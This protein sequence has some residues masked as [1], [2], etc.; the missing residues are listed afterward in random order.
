MDRT[1]IGLA[2]FDTYVDIDSVIGVPDAAAQAAGAGAGRTAPPSCGP[3]HGLLC[4]VGAAKQRVINAYQST[5][6]YTHCEVYFPKSVFTRAELARII[7]PPPHIMS[8]VHE[9]DMVVAFAAFSDVRPEDIARAKGIPFNRATCKQSHGVVAMMRT[10]TSPKYKTLTISVDVAAFNRTRAFALNQLGRPY[11]FSAAS[12]RI[13]LFPPAPTTRRYWCASL[14]HAIL[15]HASLLRWQ[16]LNTLD[17]TKIVTLVN[18]SGRIDYNRGRPRQMRLTREL[19]VG[20]LFP[21]SHGIGTTRDTVGEIIQG[22]RAIA[23]D[24]CQT[25]IPV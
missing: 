12:W 1:T 25:A 22:A 11:D 16:P 18:L 15:K 2:F 10:F 7:H 3:L 23:A 20:L 6:R 9:S 4:G 17:V 5:K 14:A 19:F 21:P 24:S 13:V 8:G